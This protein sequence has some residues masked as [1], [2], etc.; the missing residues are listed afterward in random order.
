MSDDPKPTGLTILGQCTNGL[1]LVSDRV[2]S[3]E[4]ESYPRRQP[5]PAR[6]RLRGPAPWRPKLNEAKAI[7]MPTIAAVARQ[8]IDRNFGVP[9]VHTVHY[10]GGADTVLE[11]R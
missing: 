11:N 10:R 1:C 8:A 7:D 4:W 3:F 2:R 9:N 5:K 6:E